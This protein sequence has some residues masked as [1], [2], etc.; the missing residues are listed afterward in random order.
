MSAAVCRSVIT[1]R[2]ATWSIGLAAATVLLVAWSR[3][4]LF[5]RSALTVGP[6]CSHNVKGWRFQIDRGVGVQCVKVDP[7]DPQVYWGANAVL[8]VSRELPSY[9]PDAELPACDVPRWCIVQRAA[10]RDRL[11]VPDPVYWREEA[12][13]WP[14]VCV[15]QI[16]IMSLTQNTYALYG[17][18]PLGRRPNQFRAS[19]ST[20]PYMPR[21]SGLGV[22]L[23]FWS[24]AWLSLIATVGHMRERRRRLKGL[25]PGCGYD[26][27]F[28]DERCPECGRMIRQE[29]PC[30]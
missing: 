11:P 27:R 18:V 15:H 28:S 7:A 12:F 22:N 17:G 13:G 9:R 3:S 29:S 30:T 16:W 5:T 23:A 10:D 8:T 4:L 25:C 1:W 14:M 26:L 6:E 24:C 19:G 2:A 20:L 21:W